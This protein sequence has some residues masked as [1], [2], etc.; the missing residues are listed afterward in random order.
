MSFPCLRLQRVESNVKDALLEGSLL[1]IYGQVLMVSWLPASISAGERPSLWRAVF[2]FQKVVVETGL[3][4]RLVNLSIVYGGSPWLRAR[5]LLW[6]HPWQILS[7]FGSDFVV[8]TEAFGFPARMSKV[9]KV[10]PKA[11]R[12]LFL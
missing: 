4:N 6:L 9:S 12:S 3:K 1:G 2:M 10:Q 11:E 5:R 8:L 7:I